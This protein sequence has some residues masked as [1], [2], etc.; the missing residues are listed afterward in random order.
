[1][2]RYLVV[3]CYCAAVAVVA[4]D[5]WERRETWKAADRCAV[6]SDGK[7]VHREA[8]RWHYCL[9]YGYAD[10]Q[11]V[12]RPLGYRL[13]VGEDVPAWHCRIRGER[14]RLAERA[15]F[16]VYRV[17]DVSGGIVHGRPP[18]RGGRV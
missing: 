4:C 16:R 14:V 10:P 9:L 11:S 15:G 18:S 1:M 12:R 6:G 7:L 3:V 8:A 17:R 2:R 5:V 13:A